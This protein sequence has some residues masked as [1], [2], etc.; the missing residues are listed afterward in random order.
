MAYT[1]SNAKSDLNGMLQ[2]TTTDKITSINSLFNR[3]GRQLLLDIDPHETKRITQFNLFDSGSNDI[4]NYS[5]PSD[6]KG[7]KIIDIRPQINRSVR[8]NFSQQYDE[9]FDQYKARNTNKLNIQFDEGTKI[10]RI[11]KNLTAGTS[12]NS[13]DDTENNGT[14]T[15]GDDAENLTQDKVNKKQGGAS[16]NFDVDGS[17]TTASLVNSTM[18]EIDFGTDGVDHVNKSTLFQW[19]FF[20]SASV[21][22]SVNLKWGSSASNTWDRTITAPFFGSFVDGWNLLNFD[23]NGATVTG[24]P[25]ESA[26]NYLKTLITYDGVADTDFRLDQVISRLPEIWEQVYYS[27]FLFRTTT[28]VWQEK[29]TKDSDLINLD[30]ESY[31]VWLWKVAEYAAQ[32]I[33]DLKDFVTYFKNEYELSKKRYVAQNK[34]EVI[35]P[36]ATYYRI[37]RGRRGDGRRGLN[38]VTR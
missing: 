27:N 20:P 34:G 13:L 22:T 6:L 8:D 17:G 15:A 12:I 9:E 7:K 29:T 18:A 2:G 35:Q 37:G 24:S 5:S 30:T 19:A 28:G 3:A 32:Q 11:A 38:R 25:D 36:Q 4:Y 33:E 23:W 10:L 26:V 16:L 1:I 31:N 14:W 21:I